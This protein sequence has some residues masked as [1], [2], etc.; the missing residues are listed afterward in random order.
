MGKKKTSGNLLKS[1]VS[2]SRLFKIRERIYLTLYDSKAPVL[3]FFK[4][5]SILVS[6][7]ALGSITIY[8]GFPKDLATI[9]YSSIIIN[10]SLF[11]YGIKY[12][13][14]WFYNYNMLEYLKSNWTQ[15]LILLVFMVYISVTAISDR[16]VFE[17]LTL[18]LNSEHIA[19]YSLILIQIYF[20]VVVFLEVASSS[21]KIANLNLNPAMLLLLSFLILI[22]VGTGLLMLPE[23]TNGGI[24]FLDALFTSTSASCVTGLIV[25][26]TA[27]AFTY[28]GQI[29]IMLL[30][31]LGGINIISFATFFVTFSRKAGGLKYQSLLKDFLSAEKLSDS[32]L[33]LRQI[34]LF[35]FLFELL[36]TLLIYFS[37]GEQTMFADTAHKIFYSAFHSVSA[38]NNAGFSLFTNNLFESGIRQLYGLQ[39]IIIF[40]VFFGGLGFITIQDVFSFDKL[41]LK[42]NPWRKLQVNTKVTL[43]F[44]IS[45]VVVGSVLFYYLEKGNTLKE[46]HGAGLIITSLFQSVTTRT[47]GFNTVDIGAL[48]M[49][50][51]ILFMFLMFIGASSGS[52]GGGIKVTTFA[53]IIKSAIATIRGQKNVEFFKRNISF[54]VVNRAYSIT[55]FS[56]TVI[57]VS[58][59]LLAITE[60]DKS[61]MQLIFEEFSAFGTVGLST[62]ITA[63]LSPAGK[64]II[65]ISMFIG[66]IGTLTLALAISKKVISSKYKYAD[67][68]MMVG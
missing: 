68:A 25:V 18:H 23:L 47:A 57:F 53:I 52:T 38:F 3:S 64:I 42:R 56:F 24:S 39:L 14:K 33:I 50:V 21:A 13:V 45:L 44:S 35:S 55:L 6:L 48:A 41:K 60:H 58:V 11:F 36:G 20:L 63:S 37:W 32:R 5:S 49:P 1:I 9:E 30:I 54:K 19:T 12:L 22:S 51:M 29:V 15:G 7:V 66:R 4:Y 26:D 2:M 67:A 27:T 34:V 62:G 46:Q 61:F 40:L 8:Y 16:S 28:K 59:F 17:M 10:V 43:L 65:L 31:Q